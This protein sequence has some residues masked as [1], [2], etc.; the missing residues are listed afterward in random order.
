M[1]LIL[2]VEDEKLLRWAL[3]QQLARA[4][5]SVVSAP[6]LATAATHLAAAQPDVVLLDLGLPDGHG[7]DFYESNRERLEGS[8]VIVMTALGQ[9]GEAVRAMKLGALDFLTKPVD[10]AD[11]VALV[12]RSLHVRGDRLE[13]QASRRYREQTLAQTVIGDSPAFRRVLE[14]AEQVAQSEVGTVLVQGESGSGKNVVARHIHACSARRDRPLLEVSCAT[15]PENLLESEL[16]G[17]EKGAFT[18]AKAV[19]R[20]VF[21]LAEGGTVVLDEIGELR[22]DLQ[23]KLLHFLEE[24]RF[25][26]VGGTREIV[27]D[28]RVVALTNRDLAAMVRDRTF[29]GDLFYRLAV[30]PIDMPPLRE[31]T[32]DILPLARHFLA[33]LQ[34]KLGR[35]FDGFDRAAENLLLANSWPGNVRELRNVI[36]RAVLLAETPESEQ[37]LRRAPPP[38]PAKTDMTPSTTASSPDASMTV[39]VDI[40]T[41]FKVAKQ[42][43]VSEFERRYISKLLAHHD[44]NISAAARAAGIDR[45]SIHKML[46]R[47]GLANPGRDDMPPG[48]F[49]ISPDDDE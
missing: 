2:V 14:L 45:M 39:P 5:H 30:F 3:E 44:G 27:V 18:D 38:V 15:I 26:R 7:L 10:K 34:P 31:R 25:R 4:G 23:A 41:P 20:G 35:R 47:L 6:D 21:E 19:K 1:A 16:F 29:R 17:H 43:V 36:E 12:E 22:L 46:H 28:V 32:T 8:V 37:A 49:P 33:T 42:N 13:A 9:V 48:G 24:R 11:L 40:A